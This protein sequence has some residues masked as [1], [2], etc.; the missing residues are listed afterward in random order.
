MAKISARGGQAAIT[1]LKTNGA[2][3]VL[4]RT[5]RLLE[6]ALKGSGYTLVDVWRNLAVAAVLG[7]SASASASARC[8]ATKPSP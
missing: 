2:R 8:C 6:Q 7:P 1:L 3:V 4:T 5:G